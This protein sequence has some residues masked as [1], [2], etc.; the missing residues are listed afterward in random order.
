[1]RG[2]TVAEFI[3]ARVP[4]SRKPVG[5]IAREAGFKNANFLSNDARRSFQSIV[6]THIGGPRHLPAKP[7]VSL[8]GGIR[9]G[10]SEDDSA[11]PAGAFLSDSDL[12]LMK[13]IKGKLAVL[14]A[15]TAPKSR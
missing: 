5:Q 15:R 1:M 10:T 13:T 3:T 11:V 14:R 4:L 6:C 2:L 8:L 12:E 7:P 9:P